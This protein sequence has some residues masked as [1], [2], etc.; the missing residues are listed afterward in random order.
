MHCLFTGSL[1]AEGRLEASVGLAALVV[2]RRKK[3]K[4]QKATMCM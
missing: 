2:V 1:A 4:H 3:N